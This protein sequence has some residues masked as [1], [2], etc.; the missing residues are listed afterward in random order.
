MGS[1]SYKISGTTVICQKKGCRLNCYT[2]TTVAPTSATGS[3]HQQLFDKCVASKKCDKNKPCY[4]GGSIQP[5]GKFS[6]SSGT[7]NV[8]NHR[9]RNLKDTKHEKPMS[10]GMKKAKS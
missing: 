4:Y 1:L 2:E 8:P 5:D 9:A 3:R 10:K 6:Y 7:C